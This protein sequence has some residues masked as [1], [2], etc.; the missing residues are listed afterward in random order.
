MNSFS[1]ASNIQTNYWDIILLI[2][3]SD[4]IMDLWKWPFM[5]CVTQL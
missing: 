3:S 4:P 1:E 2:H 5:Q